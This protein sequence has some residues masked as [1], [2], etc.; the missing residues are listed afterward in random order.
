MSVGDSPSLKT[1]ADIIEDVAP[2]S[3]SE[4]YGIN[5]SGGGSSPASGTISLSDFRNQIIFTGFTERAKLT[6]SDAAA[7][8]S[9]GFSVA[10]SGDYA[11]VGARANDDTGTDSGSAYIFHRTD[12]NTWDAGTKI[13]ASDAAQE[14]FFGHSVAI[15][16]DYA[17]VGAYGNDDGG[18]QSGSVYIFH[19]TDTNTWDAG[20]KIIVFWDD[21]F[22]DFFGWSVAISGDYAIAGAY[23][24]DD[25][26]ESS[27]S[28]Y[29]FRRTDTNTWDRGTKIVASDAAT[30]DFFGRS[31]A[32]SGDYAIVGAYGNDDGGFTSGSAYIFRRTSD[33]NTWDAGTKIVASDAAAYDSFGYG[34]SISGDYAIVGAYGNDDS[35]SQSGSAYIFHRTDTNTWDAG[36]KIVASDATDS[37]NF[38]F[39]VAISGDYAIVGAYTDSDIA[40]TA[41]SAYI[42]RR[43][44]TNTWDAGTKIVASD[45]TS[46]DY[47]GYSVSISGNTSIVGAFFDDDGGSQSG[48]AYIFG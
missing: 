42:F 2:H 25:T 27:G 43:T 10:V 41:G 15:S 29:I 34:V 24:N 22:Q 40:S 47:F 13:V 9:F 36:T 19:R 1:I 20:T 18:S 46:G 32:I 8:D 16:G 4:M 23:G 7:N 44:D 21:S 26:G 28:A 39:S 12:T 30:L 14:D 5:F 35:G 17:I 45:A 48:S 33:A 37:D 31:V 38:G 3:M 6:A 11:I